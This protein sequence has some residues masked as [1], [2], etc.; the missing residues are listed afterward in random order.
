MSDFLRSYLTVGIFGIV[1]V[2]LVGAVVVGVLVCYLHPVTMPR[3][4]EQLL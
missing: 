3:E 2:A 1:G 4:A